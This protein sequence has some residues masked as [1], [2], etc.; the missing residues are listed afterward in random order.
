M[1][2]SIYLH[3]EIYNILRCFGQLDDVVDKML[4]AWENGEIDISCK[5][6][7]PG[8]DNAKR[9]DIEIRNRTYLAILSEEGPNSFRYSLRRALY[10]FVEEEI[11]NEL[12]WTMET[13][14]VNKQFEKFVNDVKK[15][16][17]ILIKAKSRGIT[18]EKKV[19]IDKA[20]F[21]IGEI[22]C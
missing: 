6:P 8:R 5:Q 15:A 21:Y 11:Y 9:Y 3:D 14:F 20:L 13:K 2:L 16:E 22:L 12:R 1:K 18:I 10:W 19:L 4:K 17:A 7:C